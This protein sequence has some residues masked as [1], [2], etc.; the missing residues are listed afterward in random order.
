MCIRDRGYPERAQAHALSPYGSSLGIAVEAVGT[1]GVVKHGAVLR[2]AERRGHWASGWVGGLQLV[3]GVEHRWVGIVNASPTAP[4]RD[5][6]NLWREEP[7]PSLGGFA[8]CDEPLPLSGWRW[9][10]EPFEWIEDIPDQARAEGEGTNLWRHHALVFPD[11]RAV[12]FYNSGAYF[13][14]QLYLKVSA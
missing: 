7:P 5:D 10:D 8:I 12:L 4:D 13:E 3:R 6:T 14:E 11:G 2:P 9:S 1:S